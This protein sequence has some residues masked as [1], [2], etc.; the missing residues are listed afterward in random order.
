MTTDSAP[1]ATPV[2]ADKTVDSTA[3]VP[4]ADSAVP[5]TPIKKKRRN[6][7]GLASFIFALILIAWI[8]G[9][10]WFTYQSLS[11]VKLDSAADALSPGTAAAFNTLTA[12]YGASIGVVPLLGF[13]TL[14]LAIIAL[15]I[16]GIPG[17]LLGL[18]SLLILI[19]VTVAIVVGIGLI[20]TE[21][22]K[23]SEQYG[24]LLKSLLPLLSS[25][26]G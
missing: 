5:E 19:A 6:R 26:S 9:I 24:P 7:L 3:A 11:G 14:I 10:G 23:L 15:V 21:V 25:Y 1:E 16:N 2:K 4:A 12:L 13:V 22:G 18:L 8:G 17:K 20:V